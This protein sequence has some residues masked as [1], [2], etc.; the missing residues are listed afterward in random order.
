MTTMNNGLTKKV[1]IEAFEDHAVSIYRYIYI[2]I[3][4]N[5]EIAED[6]SQ[7]VFYKVWNRRNDFDK[8]K[9]SL[10]SWL[11]LIAQGLIID[12]YRKSTS[13]GKDKKAELDTEEIEKFGD[14]SNT[15]ISDELLSEWILSKM[16]SLS[17]EEQE[18]IILRYIEDEN[19]KVIS[20]II[21]K[22]ESATKVS[23]HRAINKLR[24]IINEE[25]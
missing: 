22:K 17:E 14:T 25:S 15:D 20:E 5:R 1:L 13:K 3:G 23:I 18:L 10:K 8:S 6:L 4:M 19:I 11:Y 16:K 9:S 12:H 2:R 24:E 7:E 21:G